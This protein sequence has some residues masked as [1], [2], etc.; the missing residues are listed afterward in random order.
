MSQIVS[1]LAKNPSEYQLKAQNPWVTSLMC[2]DMYAPN[3]PRDYSRLLESEGPDS[4]P[5]LSKLLYESGPD[6]EN[7]HTVIHPLGNID[8]TD[9]RL[10]TAMLIVFIE[11]SAT[12]DSLKILISEVVGSIASKSGYPLVAFENGV[13]EQE[14]PYIKVE[15]AGVPMDPS[16]RV[17]A[18]GPLW[19]LFAGTV[20][21]VSPGPDGRE[22]I[23]S[24]M[25]MI[26]GTDT[27]FYSNLTKNVYRYVAAG[28]DA[29]SGIH[30][31]NERG[32]ISA[33]FDI[34]KFLYGIVQNMDEY[35][36]PE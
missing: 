6:R 30:G 10:V 9:P 18:A 17:E 13:P 35:D 24:P 27:M 31:V 1:A 20:K 33:H 12:V 2:A 28:T 32:K 14:A 26:G 16:H 15:M 8:S 3:F 34:M 5:E 22:R 36:G 29:C 7:L 19:D 21:S 23:V 11:Y 25:T 4:W